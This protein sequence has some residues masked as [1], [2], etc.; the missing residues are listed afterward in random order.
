MAEPVYGH[1]DFVM[2]NELPG[3]GVGGELK[4]LQ[5]TKVLKL[6]LRDIL[7]EGS[8]PSLLRLSGK[9][10]QSEGECIFLEILV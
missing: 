10:V 9:D 6:N 4:V 1:I 3:C 7:K 8:K 5:V 2:V